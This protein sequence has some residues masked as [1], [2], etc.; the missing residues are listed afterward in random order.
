MQKGK[1]FMPTIR[2]AARAAALFVVAAGLAI[3][4]PVQAPAAGKDYR[5]ELVGPP[6][7]SGKAT[8]VKV[9]LIHVPDGKPVPGAIIIQTKFDMR[10]AGMASMTAPAKL[11]APADGGFYQIE[12]EPE[13]AGNWALT[14]SAKV[15]GEQETVNGTVTVPIAK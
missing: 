4:A 6:V 5:F 3:G 12:A 10:P 2:V 14:L 7:K 13:M 1:Q 8:L 11:I 9:K 15:Q